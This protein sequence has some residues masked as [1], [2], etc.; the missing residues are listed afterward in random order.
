MPLVT[1]LALP[2]LGSILAAL[3]PAN[4]RTTESTLAG[5]IALVCTAQAAWLYPDI[6]QGGVLRQEI[7]WLP[8]YG[9][10]LVTQ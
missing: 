10:S 4:A 2:F 3:L 9:L 7:E 1:L 8:Q 6:A 5:L